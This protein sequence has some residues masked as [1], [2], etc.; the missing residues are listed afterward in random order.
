MNRFIFGISK[1]KVH[2]ITLTAIQLSLTIVFQY[3][4]SFFGQ[5]LITGSV[6]N[7]MLLLNTLFIGI[8]GSIIIALLTPFIGLLIGMANNIIF[9]PFIAISN[10]LY[11]VSFMI[12]IKLFNKKDTKE[13]INIIILFISLIIASS[14]KFLFMYFITYKLILP[15][16]LV[17]V[18][19][20]LSITFGTIQLFT[21]LIGGTLSIIIS[22]FLKRIKKETV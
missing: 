6:V 21:A 2:F 9:V 12:F 15:L 19:K 5:Q 3:L 18:P 22:R 16:I 17:N 8:L 10:V 4:S 11:V 20:Q 7:M 14:I 13:F 1:N